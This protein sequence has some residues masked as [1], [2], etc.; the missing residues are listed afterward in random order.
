MTFNELILLM[1]SNGCNLSDIAIGRM[2]III[3]E[4][5][6]NFPDYDDPAPLWVIDQCIDKTIDIVKN[7]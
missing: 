4:Q 2:M 7:K 3:E 6:G 5:T 1:E